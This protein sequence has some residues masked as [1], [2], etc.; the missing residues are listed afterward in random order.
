MKLIVKTDL[1]YRSTRE[2]A[3]MAEEIRKDIGNCE[4]RRRQ[5]YAALANIRK[6][7]TQ[8]KIVRPTL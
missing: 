5:N 7:Q 6:V 8:R 3:G 2:L 1:Y 4:Q